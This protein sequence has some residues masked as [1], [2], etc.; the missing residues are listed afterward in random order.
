[1]LDDGLT[2]WWDCSHKQPMN[3]GQTAR[4]TM[5]LA[6]EFLFEGKGCNMFGAIPGLTII[7]Y[8]VHG[9]KERRLGYCCNLFSCNVCE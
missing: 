7:N 8:Y 5:S 4:R 6:G 1:M 3:G 9:E 2:K